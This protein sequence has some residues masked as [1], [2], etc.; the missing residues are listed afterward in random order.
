[1]QKREAFATCVPRQSSAALAKTCGGVKYSQSAT[2]FDCIMCRLQEGIHGH[3]DLLLQQ[4]LSDIAVVIAHREY[5][6]KFKSRFCLIV[7]VLI[8]YLQF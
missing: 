4:L 7:V 1:M 3:R 2:F 8:I 5:D 6:T